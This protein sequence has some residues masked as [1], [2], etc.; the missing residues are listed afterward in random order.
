MGSASAATITIDAASAW[1]GS[2]STT[3]P[4]GITLLS[5]G[6]NGSSNTLVTSTGFTANGVAIGFSGGSPASGEY[7]G[8][9]AG[10]YS[11]VFGGNNGN[12]NYLVAGGT[13]GA[14]T[15][16]F[17][18]SQTSLTILWGTVDSE[19]GRNVVV[20]TS[21][22]TDTITGAQILAACGATTCG[23]GFGHTS[24]GA[25]D[26]YVTITGLN[27]FTTATFSDTGASA[28]EFDLAVPT[29]TPLPGA[30]SLFAG[31]LGVLGLLARRKK[32]KGVL[33]SA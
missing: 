27:S 4:A 29:A 25:Y 23:D 12:A 2:S 28:F 24:S 9:S 15:A 33:V 20:T 6:T 11:S 5:L 1:A 21:A 26:V 14:V 3:P 22:G 30:L 31:G 8:N 32:R 19:A 16:T 18:S 17:G 10:N 13:T 7:A